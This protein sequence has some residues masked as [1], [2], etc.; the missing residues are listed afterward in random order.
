MTIPAAALP[1]P[2]R[3]HAQVAASPAYYY[4]VTSDD[5]FEPL[6]LL[7]PTCIET[8]SHMA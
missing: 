6:C 2:P 8:Y 7:T 4:L 1:M 5:S 3:T